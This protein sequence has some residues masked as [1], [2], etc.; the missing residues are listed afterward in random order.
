MGFERF[1]TATLRDFVSQQV[2]YHSNAGSV[3]KA[4]YKYDEKW[5]VLKQRK[6]SELGHTKNILNEVQLLM[7]L[8]HPNVVRCF[9]HF[10]ED[11]RTSLY[12]VLEYCSGGDLMALINVHRKASDYFEE[13]YIWSLFYQICDGTFKKYFSRQKIYM[14]S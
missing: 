9:G 2:L 6:V 3:I 8:N 14:L 10:W 1:S 11:G 12:I 5:Y 7:Q 13:S 4:Q